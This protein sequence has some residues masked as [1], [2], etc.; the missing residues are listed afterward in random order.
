ML[1][2]RSP[3]DGLKCILDLFTLHVPVSVLFEELY[4][5]RVPRAWITPRSGG[6]DGLTV[7]LLTHSLVDHI[8]VVLV[9]LN[10]RFPGPSQYLRLSRP[11]RE[12]DED[13][14]NGLDRDGH[15]ARLRVWNLR[16]RS[17]EH[18]SELQ[19]HVNLVC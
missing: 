4:G 7:N 14:N 8:D 18:T 11:T 3:A 16:R 17:E 6:S 5:S 12:T 10:V 9:Q 15:S 1:G 19:S 13:Q 2:V